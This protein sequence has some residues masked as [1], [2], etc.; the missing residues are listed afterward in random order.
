VSTLSDKAVE[1]HA[2]DGLAEGI[3]VVDVRE[4]LARFLEMSPSFHRPL[5]VMGALCI[6]SVDHVR[7]DLHRGAVEAVQH[8]VAN[9]QGPIVAL[10]YTER[11]PRTEAYREVMAQAGR[12]AEVVPIPDETRPSNR[13]LVVDYV[14]SRGCPSAFFCQNDD[15]A[16]AA[17]RA[18]CDC[19][20]R[21]P[22]DVA[23][24]GCDGIEDSEYLPVPLTTIIHPVEEMTALAWQFLADR[25]SDPTRPV[26]SA[27]IPSRLVVR[28]SSR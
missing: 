17:Y 13:R 5:V 22:D 26:Q 2:P 9:R 4:P 21:V 8:L 1:W 14:R 12:P 18:L 3:L 19:G 6:T 10:M 24:V 20:I 28:E 27:T 23:L 25:M 7:I 15:V 16:L 11:D